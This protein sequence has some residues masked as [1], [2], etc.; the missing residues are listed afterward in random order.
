MNPQRFSW[1]NISKLL[2][3]PAKSHAMRDFFTKGGIDVGTLWEYTPIGI[4]GK[5]IAP[6]RDLAEID[7][8]S[9]CGVQLQFGWG[10]L[11]AGFEELGS[12]FIFDGIKYY[13]EGED[14]ARGY[15]GSMPFGFTFSDTESVFLAK[16]E[17]PSQTRG[18]NATGVYRFHRW[19]FRE[20][21]VQAVFLSKTLLLRRV[22]AYLPMKR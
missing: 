21:T 6:P 16:V 4:M 1:E 10:S 13:A 9:R 5:T 19:D 20:Y 2:G 14:S 17:Q 22:M 18:G 7:F 15:D 8:K 3:Q 12:E 11:H